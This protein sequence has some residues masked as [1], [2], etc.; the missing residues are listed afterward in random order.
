[1]G[2]QKN[3]SWVISSE[4]TGKK[5]WSLSVMQHS[6]TSSGVPVGILKQVYVASTLKS[7]P[8]VCVNAGSQPADD[9]GKPPPSSSQRSWMLAEPHSVKTYSIKNTYSTSV[10]KY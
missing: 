1:M 4:A 8:V 6:G 10:E 9:Q 5:C 3:G 7:Q 2:A